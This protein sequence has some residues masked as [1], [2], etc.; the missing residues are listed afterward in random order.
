MLGVISFPP[1]RFN[2]SPPV[3]PPLSPSIFLH[4]FA[5]PPPTT[6]PAR[7]ASASFRLKRA[8]SITPASASDEKLADHCTNVEPSLPP[9]VM[10]KQRI[11]DSTL[12]YVR[13]GVDAMTE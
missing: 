12:V 6:T 13:A 5:L 10:G 1:S 4:F 8:S 9:D 11:V 7:S 2:T 3:F